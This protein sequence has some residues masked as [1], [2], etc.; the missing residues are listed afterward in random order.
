[1]A[2]KCEPQLAEAKSILVVLQTRMGI[3]HA[4]HAT[5]MPCDLSL[6]LNLGPSAQGLAT[7]FF[8][9]W[10]LSVLHLTSEE[11]H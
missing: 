5:L 9:S 7:A 4:C 10:I 1:M 8:P 6:R 3:S 2:P 11:D